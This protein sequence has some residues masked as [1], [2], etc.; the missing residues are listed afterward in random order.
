MNLVVLM[1]RPTTD[2]ELRTTASGVSVASFSLAVDRYT[3][4]GEEKKA[5][6][7][8]I[9]AWKQKAEF[10]ANYIKKGQLIA[11][12]GAIQTRK[13]Q[14]KDG[15]NRIAFEVVASNVHFAESKKDGSYTPANTSK[16]NVPVDDFPTFDS[17]D[18][19]PFN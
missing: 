12:E 18:D 8:N 9:V 16:P 1:G 19:L 10:A 2:I 6:F 7:I 5:N 17:G 4:A 3:K 11:I 13:Y 15:N 14:D